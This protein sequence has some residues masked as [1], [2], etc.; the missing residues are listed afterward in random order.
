MTIDRTTFESIYAGQPRWEIGR[1]QRAFIDLADQIT[2]SI[3]D[4]GCGTGENAFFFVSRGNEVAGVDF[5]DEPI[6]IAKRKATERGLTVTFL[7]MDALTLK[8]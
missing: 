8:D 5:L 6:T 3:L 1:P 7:V 4:S 2:G